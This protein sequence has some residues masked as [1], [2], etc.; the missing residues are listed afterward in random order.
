MHPKHAPTPSHDVS[1]T[2]QSSFGGGNQSSRRGWGRD[3]TER[4]RR[5]FPITQSA[6]EQRFVLTHRPDFNTPYC[7]S[8]RSSTVLCHPWPPTAEAEGR[9]ESGCQ[10]ADGACQER[11]KHLEPSVEARCSRSHEADRR[12]LDAS[13]SVRP[14]IHPSIHPSVAWRMI[15]HPSLDPQSFPSILSLSPP[16]R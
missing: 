7:L 11:R 14:F 5:E 8:F 13:R 3:L 4:P 1:C 10:S 16:A 6:A 12:G 9:Q 2:R 15:Y